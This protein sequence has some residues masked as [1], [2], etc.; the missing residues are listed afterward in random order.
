MRRAE[1]VEAVADAEFL[2]NYTP[3]VITGAVTT[4]LK[5][6]QHD[7]EACTDCSSWKYRKQVL[8]GRGNPYAKLMVLSDGPSPGD[9]EEGDLFT[10]EP[11]T[12]LDKMLAALGLIDGEYYLC[13]TVKCYCGSPDGAPPQEFVE[14]CR[15]LLHGQISSIRPRVILAMGFPVFIDL[16]PEAQREWGQLGSYSVPESEQGAEYTAAVVVCPHPRSVRPGTGDETLRRGVGRA[17]G[18]VKRLL[19]GQND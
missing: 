11:G 1:A 2:E 14:E 8:F 6:L 17:L 18:V 16:C 9:D 19:G 5:I 13:N 15:G 12:T 7:A 4:R 10:G 3:A